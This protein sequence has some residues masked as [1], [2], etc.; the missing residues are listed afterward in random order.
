MNDGNDNAKKSQLR[1]FDDNGGQYL[2]SVNFCIPG[3]MSRCGAGKSW[4]Q[5][6]KCKFA[7]KSTVSDRCMYYME[8]IYGHCDCLEAQMDSRNTAGS[9]APGSE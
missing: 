7:I 2:E 4:A 6:K 9:K 8:S 1:E 3:T 5:Q